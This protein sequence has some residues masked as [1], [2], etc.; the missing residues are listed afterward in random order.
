YISV[1]L[2]EQLSLL[3]PFGKGNPKPVF[4]QKGI[5][6]LNPRILGKNRNVVKMRV[7][8]QDGFSMEAVYFG[9]AEKFLADVSCQD[10]VSITYYP[11]INRYQGRESLQIVIQNYC[12]KA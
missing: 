11:E 4:A 12:K 6:V 5:H 1:P 2:V 10:A 3:E 9:E 7:L 8:D